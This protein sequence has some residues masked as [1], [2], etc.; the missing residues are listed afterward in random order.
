VIYL[1]KDIEIRLT[2]LP[3]EEQ[4]PDLRGVLNARESALNRKSSRVKL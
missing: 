2:H 4:R 1:K 3:R